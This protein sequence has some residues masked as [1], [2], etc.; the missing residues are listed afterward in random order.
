MCKHALRQQLEKSYQ[1]H[2][3][4]R[5]FDPLRLELKEDGKVLQVSF[6]HAFFG[7]WFMDI[8]KQDFERHAIA[9]F[10]G[11][12]ISY[13]QHFFFHHDDS[14]VRSHIPGFSGGIAKGKKTDVY[15]PSSCGQDTNNSPSFFSKT[16]QAIGLPVIENQLFDNFL[17]NKKNEMALEA[18][19]QAANSGISGNTLV[20]Y[21]KSCTGK[22]HILSAM[23]NFLKM[24]G[25]AF[26]F[27]N[28]HH[29]NRLPL[30]SDLTQI[31]EEAV[32]IDDGHR[33]ANNADIQDVL[34]SLIDQF[35][36]CGKLLVISL[37]AH[38][39]HCFG[40]N[41]KLLSR[42]Y[43]GLVMELKKPDLDIRTQY[44]E[45]Q[46]RIH[47]FRLSKDKIL[48]IAQ[49]FTDIRLIDGFITRFAFYRDMRQKHAQEEN[50]VYIPDV[51]EFLEQGE[52]RNSLTHNGIINTVARNFSVSPNDITG[53]SR[54]K[55]IT[56]ARHIAIMLCREL[57]GLSL[58]QVGRLFGNRD[59]SSVIH[60]IKKINHL[61]DSDKHMHSEVEKIRK[62]CLHGE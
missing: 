56:L 57:L 9:L 30:S 39:S 36:V 8:L 51:R 62:L 42:L 53:K 14:P 2:D 49:R 11:I 54:D 37:D 58:P 50:E 16:G 3:L 61:Q 33:L 23:A 32:F 10:D 35:K 17:V 26:I 44:V 47:N 31:T 46:N 48:S 21:G 45:Q 7:R 43:G 41:Q 4:S 25:R 52:N 28:N 27:S 18:A 34:A 6:P 15:Y 13:N 12:H 19:K 1:N 40:S 5:W 38:P 22:S 60:S 29:G 59:H 24:R 55:K 20:L